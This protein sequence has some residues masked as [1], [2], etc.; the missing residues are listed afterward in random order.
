MADARSELRHRREADGV[1]GRRERCPV[2]A[3][4]R[5]EQWRLGHDREDALHPAPLHERRHRAYD[6][7]RFAE[8][9]H[10]AKRPV[11]GRLLLLR[12]VARGYGRA[13]DRVATIMAIAKTIALTITPM[14]R[15]C[16]NVVT[17]TSCRNVQATAE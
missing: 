5:N 16:A 10:H 8:R 15:P 6:D 12:P 14:I 1:H 7:L 13:R 2:A 11:H 9:R 17:E 3:F 4:E